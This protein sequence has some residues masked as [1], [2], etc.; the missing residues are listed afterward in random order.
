MAQ[1]T[2]A[3]Q[4]IGRVIPMRLLVVPE[5][6]N[7]DYWNRVTSWYVLI[8]QLATRLRGLKPGT[9]RNMDYQSPQG[10]QETTPQRADWRLSEPHHTIR[11]RFHLFPII[12]I[13]RYCQFASIAQYITK[14]I[15]PGDAR[16]RR[17]SA[18][19]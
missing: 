5:P 4:V 19:F 9:E 6:A 10:V 14:C 16:D 18:I 1:Q 13:W 11:L 2:N 17:A 8:E 15:C 3:V 7:K 12:I